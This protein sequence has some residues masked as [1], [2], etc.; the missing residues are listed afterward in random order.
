MMLT[1]LVSGPKQPGDRID[2]YLRPLVDD[3]KILWKPGV[4]EVWDEYKHEEFTM[5]GMLFTTINDNLTQRNLSGQSKRKGAAC[6]HCLE[7]T[8]PTWLRHSK[9]Y[10]FMG[11]RR[12]L[13]KKHPYRAIDCQFNGEKE[14]RE[15][16]LHVTGDLVHSK[17]KDI[18]T[19][20]ELPKLIEKTLGK[21]KKQ[22]GEEEEGM[23]NK[24][25]ILWEVEYWLMLDVRHRLTTCTSRRM[26]VKLLVEHCYNISPKEKIIQ[27]QGRILKSWALGRS[28]MQ[29][30]QR[31][32]RTFTLLQPPCQRKREKN[33]VSFCMI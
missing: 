5:H 22:D 32:G 7:D 27:M 16:P 21:R 15:A 6:P 13:G 30:R 14:N 31:W 4:S 29:R 9:K 26:C 18:K 19:I 24:K 25:S 8:C 11:H 17:V 23:W 28:S 1:I 2:V 10:V 3:L 20:E 12:F 33:S